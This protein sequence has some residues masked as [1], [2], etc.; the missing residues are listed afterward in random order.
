MPH[1]TTATPTAART[2]RPASATPGPSHRTPTT[3]IPV[4]P[5]WQGLA[6]LFAP[7]DSAAVR[8]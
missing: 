4:M 7:A 3:A 6:Q 2:G 8:P 1:T 5:L